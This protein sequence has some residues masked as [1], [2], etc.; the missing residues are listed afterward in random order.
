M[1]G[2]GLLAKPTSCRVSI[3]SGRVPLVI[4]FSALGCFWGCCGREPWLYAEVF[5]LE[6]RFRVWVSGAGRPWIFWV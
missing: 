5:A 3:T 6:A 4:V 2:V 1:L